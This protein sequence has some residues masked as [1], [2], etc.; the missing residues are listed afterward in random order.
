M[1]ND[2]RMGPVTQER[3]L[4]LNLPATTPVWTQGLNNWQPIERLPEF[5][6]HYGHPSPFDPEYDI[7]PGF[8][9]PVNRKRT[10]AF[11]VLLGLALLTCVIGSMVAWLEIESIIG[12]GPLAS[13]LGI[14]AFIVGYRFALADKLIS[15]LP[16][17]LT[18]VCVALIN[19]FGWGPSAA[20]EPVS[21][22]ASGTTLIF[23]GLAIW[24]MVHH[25]KS[26]KG[27]NQFNHPYY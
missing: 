9:K 7:Y 22:I 10:V 12:T 5:A 14:A 2:N 16:V 15:F 19:I 25:T 18:I 24:R 8:L 27:N 3:L 4:Q 20:R 21:A 26:L 11:C 13:A 23:A 1:Q 17:A 6:N